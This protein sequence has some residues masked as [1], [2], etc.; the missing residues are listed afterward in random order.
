MHINENAPY[1]HR[2]VDRQAVTEDALR[3]YLIW[4]GSLT[5][6]LLAL[7]AAWRGA[8]YATMLINQAGVPWGLAP[9][10][11][12]MAVFLAMNS[13]VVLAEWLRPGSA[14]GPRN[15]A[16]GMF[17]TSV[18]LLSGAALEPF[19][20]EIREVLPRPLTLYLKEGI[21]SENVLSAVS[22]VLI[23]C[24]LAILDLT[25]Y[26]IHRAQHTWP[27]LWRFH[28]L[29]HALNPMNAMHAYSHVAGHIFYLAGVL[30]VVMLVVIDVPEI[31]MLSA[32]F[33][34]LNAINHSDTTVNLGPL[35]AVFTDSLT[36]RIHHSIDPKD[37][38]CNY[39]G[40]TVMWDRLFGTYRKPIDG[41][42]PQ[43]GLVD[44]PPATTLKE[45]F[46]MP[47]KKTA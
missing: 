21:A 44:T 12:T 25:Q 22:I 42:W 37:F 17:F 13:A 11:V 29:H 47:F 23:L 10:L 7:E 18:Y 38:N 6:L 30:P 27:I 46:L 43:V 41:E 8:K 35:R 36:H 4:I 45:Y 2:R 26:W 28:K 40:M 39:G 31:F 33:I 16:Q 1:V 20:R 9:Y 15:Y 19:V 32:F 14:P 34:G 3:K 5:A 24:H